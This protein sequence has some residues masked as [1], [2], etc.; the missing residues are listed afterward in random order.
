[1]GIN[2]DTPLVPA[3]KAVEDLCPVC[4]ST[5]TW[6][7]ADNLLICWQCK[8]VWPRP[9]V[10][11]KMEENVKQIF[12]KPNWPT[13]SVPLI[14]TAKLDEIQTRLVD[15]ARDAEAAARYL[16]R[17]KSERDALI[18]ESTRIRVKTLAIV[19]EILYAAAAHRQQPG[20]KDHSYFEGQSVACLTI[21]SQLSVMYGNP[22]TK[23]KEDENKL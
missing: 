9:E 2:S 17:I 15:N 16:K 1:M 10:L 5:R 7:D 19:A 14:E 23:P 22:I 13:T 4:G 21:I 6:Q 3:G 11:D 12:L 18:L 8:H 20:A